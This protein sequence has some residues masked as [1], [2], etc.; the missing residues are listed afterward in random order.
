M[1]PKVGFLCP[2]SPNSVASA[3]EVTTTI[4]QLQQESADP[5]V[6]N[7]FFNSVVELAG[8]FAIGERKPRSGNK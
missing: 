7:A 6:W 3:K 2:S 5:T 1:S 4:A 8:R